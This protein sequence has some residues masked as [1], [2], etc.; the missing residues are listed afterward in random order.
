MASSTRRVLIDDQF[1]DVAT[2]VEG[3]CPTHIKK[4]SRYSWLVCACSCTTQVFILGVLHAFGV[5][6]VE[7]IRA[8]NSTQSKAGKCLL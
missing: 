2:D 6:F 1:D 3:E 5:F 7:F 4:D 8:F